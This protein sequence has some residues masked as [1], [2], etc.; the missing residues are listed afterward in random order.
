MTMKRLEKL[1][2]VMVVLAATVLWVLGIDKLIRWI[3]GIDWYFNGTDVAENLFYACICAPIFEEL[4]YRHAPLQVLKQYTD[5]NT[6][7]GLNLTTLTVL[8]SSVI[9]GLIHGKGY[10]SIL[11]QGFV[12]LGFAIVYLRNGYSYWSAVLCHSLYNLTWMFFK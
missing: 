5:Q 2:T 1:S 10:N 11:M 9:F 7:K 6:A 3:W 12:G 8:V 4:L